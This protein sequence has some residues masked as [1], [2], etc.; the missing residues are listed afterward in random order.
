MFESDVLENGL[1]IST[2]FTEDTESTEGKGEFVD[3][4]GKRRAEDSV[5]LP[6]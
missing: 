3:W 1:R 4:P 5:A 2:E 6:T